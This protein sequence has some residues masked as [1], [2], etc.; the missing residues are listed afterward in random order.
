MI[1]KE[2]SDRRRK[3]WDNH[4][5]SE[6]GPQVSRNPTW[7]FIHMD[8]PL[9]TEL[10][11]AGREKMWVGP[12]A[13]LQAFEIYYFGENILYVILKGTKPHSEENKRFDEH[14]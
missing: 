9:G 1:A 6:A 12:T 8:Q 11:R 5:N 2:R 3:G 7:Q 14:W 4:L 13:I 10:E